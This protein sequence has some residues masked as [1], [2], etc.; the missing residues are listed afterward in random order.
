VLA[1]VVV[2]PVAAATPFIVTEEIPLLPRPES[3]AVPL[4][5]IGLDVTIWLLLWLVIATL[6]PV[7]SGQAYVTPLGELE[8]AETLGISSELFNAKKYVVPQLN[9]VTVKL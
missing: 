2:P 7:V 1:P 6:G 3:L 9:P 4:T 8:M 5:V